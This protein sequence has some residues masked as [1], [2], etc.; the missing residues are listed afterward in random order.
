[1][2]KR[3]LTEHQDIITKIQAAVG[4]D[5]DVVADLHKSVVYAE[6]LDLLFPPTSRRDA[7][8]RR[9]TY[10][11]S[12]RRGKLECPPFPPQLYSKFDTNPILKKLYERANDMPATSTPTRNGRGQRRT[13][14]ARGTSG[15]SNRPDDSSVDWSV[16]NAN[17]EVAQDDLSQDFDGMQINEDRVV[18]RRRRESTNNTPASNKK[19]V[20]GEVY[21]SNFDRRQMIF[22]PDPLT[23][24]VASF[25]STGRTS[26][27]GTKKLDALTI[28]LKLDD[29]KDYDKVILQVMPVLHFLF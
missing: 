19:G 4:G 28:F 23:G 25:N 10:L 13:T 14:F 15:N 26:D 17:P 3:N 20:S 12:K 7:N 5:D 27:D 6:T 11:T 16:D 8:N 2:A 9:Q 29:P 22:G 24:H 18:P 1:M 21:S